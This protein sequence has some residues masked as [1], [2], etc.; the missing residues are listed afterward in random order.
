M[1]RKLI[2][3]NDD[4]ID[5]PGLA[6]LYSA[7]RD[8]GECVVVAPRT[9]QSGVGHAYTTHGPLRFSCVSDGWFAVDGTPVDCTR[10]AVTHLAADAD[11][12]LAGINEGGNLGADFYTSGTVAAAREG[13]FLG[14][15]AIALSQYIRPDTPIDW[16]VTAAWARPVVEMLLRRPTTLESYFSVNL[17]HVPERRD[18]P[19]VTFCGLDP[20]QVDVRFDVEDHEEEGRYTAI[21]RGDYHGRPRLPRRDIEV[22]F[23]GEIAVTKIPVD[24]T[25]HHEEA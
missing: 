25:G 24:I 1:K 6:A 11:I 23:G 2:L 5:A 17:P 18:L 20:R 12:V 7:C 8:L 4:G 19:P 22:C 15:P 13:I 10:V 16:E 3:T 21:Y 14:L 9:H